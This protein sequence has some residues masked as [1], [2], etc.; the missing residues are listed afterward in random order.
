MAEAKEKVRL[1]REEQAKLLARNIELQA[2]V[3]RLQND[4]NKCQAVE[5]QLWFGSLESTL[6]ASHAVC[7]QPAPG[8]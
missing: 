1:A 8:F 7:R 4:W 2:A 6:G 3:G 5:G